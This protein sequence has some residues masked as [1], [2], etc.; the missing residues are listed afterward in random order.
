MYSHKDFCVEEV[1]DRAECCQAKIAGAFGEGLEHAC[2]DVGDMPADENA[3]GDTEMNAGG[4]TEMNEDLGGTCLGSAYI[5]DDP[6]FP[7][8]NYANNN[9]EW[10]GMTDWI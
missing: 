10:W 6:N 3:G 4:D 9:P 8:T 5:P 1:V 7:P 2:A